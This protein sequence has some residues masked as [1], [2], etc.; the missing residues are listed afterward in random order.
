M[1]TKA[2]LISDFEQE[3]KSTKRILERVDFS[4]V[5]WKPH[6]KSM[7]FGRLATHIA[8]LPIWTNRILEADKFDF[9][10]AN[11]TPNVARDLEDLLQIFET[12]YSNA[13][14]ALNAV[15]NDEKLEGN[16]TAV[17][18]DIPVSS[19]SKRNS[20]RHWTL[21]H[22]IHHRGQLSVYL[23]LLN[24]PVPGLYGPSADERRS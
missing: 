10:T 24:I 21:H 8:E 12:H 16:W 1:S 6:D 23:R 3:S 14:K 22:I 15:E 11:F 2:H 19:D 7:T 4:K 13:M 17:R 5:D 20:I 9:A 18:G